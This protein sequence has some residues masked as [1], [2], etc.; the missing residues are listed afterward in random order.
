MLPC[1]IGVE[2]RPPVL[3]CV[4]DAGPSRALASDRSAVGCMCLA[5]AR[6]E[7]G[8]SVLGLR[9]RGVPH[10]S[11]AC[12]ELSP[13]ENLAAASP[14]SPLQEARSAQMARSK[15]RPLGLQ[16][17]GGCL[18]AATA[19][20]RH[21]VAPFLCAP[22]PARSPIPN[23]PPSFPPA[24]LAG[25]HG[26]P[27]V[28]SASACVTATARARAT[29]PCAALTPTLTTTWASP[30]AAVSATNTAC[31]LPGAARAQ[32]TRLHGCVACRALPANTGKHRNCCDWRAR[33]Q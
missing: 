33:E 31:Q 23:H 26:S 8:S 19:T 14:S 13:A 17:G 15:L 11:W 9:A 28:P 2:N 10:L 29:P 12:A 21:H 4:G 6:H 18:A 30:T 16:L 20:L 25:T 32:P 7:V 5:P 3:F 24:V 1:M 22:H 27:A